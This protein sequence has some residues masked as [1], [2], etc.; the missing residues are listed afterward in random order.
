MKYD[1]AMNSKDK[2]SW[3]K[4]VDEEQGCMEKYKVFKAVKKNTLPKKAK[5]CHPPGQ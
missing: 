2:K 4:V 5:V 1:Q 3:A